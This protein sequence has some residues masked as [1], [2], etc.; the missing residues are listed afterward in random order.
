MEELVIRSLDG[1]RDA[2]TQLIKL[3]DVDLYRVANAKLENIE[4]INDAIQETILIGYKSIQNLEEPK[5]FKTW[6]IKILINECNKIYKQNK[7]KKGIFEELTSDNDSTI[8]NEDINLLNIENKLDLE[9][10]FKFLNCDEKIAIILFYDCNYTLPEL[11]KLLNT[12][13]NTIKSRIK[14]AKQKMRKY[15]KGGVEKNET[16]GRK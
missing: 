9:N 3:I 14:R 5:Y 12:S 13:T 8:M 1:D 16:T 15:Y 4:D 10:F 11:A 6:I 7:R 2:F